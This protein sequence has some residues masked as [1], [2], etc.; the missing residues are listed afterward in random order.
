MV[1]RQLHGGLAAYLPSLQAVQPTREADGS[2]S[3]VF[4]SQ[5]RITCR[6]NT[7]GGLL[8]EAR[9]AEL[10]LDANARRSLLLELL[11]RA[12]RQF[13]RHTEWMTMTRDRQI[14]LLQQTVPARADRI[15]V[16]SVL[17]RFVN[18]LAGWRRLAGVL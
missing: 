7:S 5:Y 11:E 2:V 14:L 6:G 17:E 15:D 12:G 16:E 4:D 3:L 18:A 1:A 8:L 13:E 9:I 10:P